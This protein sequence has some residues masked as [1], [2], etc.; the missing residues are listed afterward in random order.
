[1]VS[2]LVAAAFVL[3]KHDSAPNLKI[4]TNPKP[5]LCL[6]EVNRLRVASL[7]RYGDVEA[8]FCG[9]FLRIQRSEAACASFRMTFPDALIDPV[10]A[11][12]TRALAG[13]G[14]FAGAGFAPA[15]GAGLQSDSESY[16]SVG[17]GSYIPVKS[18][19]LNLST[20]NRRFLIC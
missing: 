19:G 16:L 10:V 5:V 9:D 1:M 15:R 11:I 3:K 14:P 4:T 7:L 18:K 8:R 20:P 6:P 12:R 2:Q 17:K 13:S